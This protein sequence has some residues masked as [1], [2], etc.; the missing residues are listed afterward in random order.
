MWKA[1]IGPVKDAYNIG[2]NP[3]FSLE[4]QSKG[5][6]AIWILLTRHITDI[7]DFRQNQEYITV[8]VYRNNGKRVYYPRK[9]LRSFTFCLKFFLL[10]TEIIRD[11]NEI[12]FLDDPPPYI[13]GVRINSPHY[14]CKIRLSEQSDTKY[15]LVISQYEK[16]N[17]IYYT[18]RVYGTCPFTL[19]K[20]P[21]LYRYEEEV[22]FLLIYFSTFFLNNFSI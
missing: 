7:A 17:T 10:A 8:L 15:S 5:T 2:D 22:Y 12:V 13:D 14:L 3:Q 4:V 20:I 16:T 18:L 19:R 9:H 11:G 1:G 21:Q 6:G